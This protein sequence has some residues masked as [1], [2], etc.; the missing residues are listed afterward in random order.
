MF[1]YT[2]VQVSVF[3]QLKLAEPRLEIAFYRVPNIYQAVSVF[4]RY[5]WRL[6]R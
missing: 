2:E 3:Y 6:R 4:L 1:D 5:L